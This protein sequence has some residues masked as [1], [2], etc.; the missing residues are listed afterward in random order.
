MK[1]TLFSPATLRSRRNCLHKVIIGLGFIGVLFC[2]WLIWNNYTS[3]K[4]LQEINVRIWQEQAEH[5]AQMLEAYFQARVREMRQWS[6]SNPVMVYFES[7]ALGMTMEY[8]LG[9]SL[10]FIR[11]SFLSSL[12][13]NRYDRAPLYSR[14]LLLDASG[15]RLVDT[16]QKEILSTGGGQASAGFNKLLTPDRT[17][18]SLHLMS[19]EHKSELLLS[20]PVFFKSKYVGQI[21]AWL[22][23]E[24]ISRKL[25]P[26]AEEPW[27]RRLEMAYLSF[28]DSIVLPSQ[29]VF[30]AQQ[31]PEL[32]PVQSDGGGL[33]QPQGEA[34]SVFLAS[35]STLGLKLDLEETPLSLVWIRSADVVQGSTSPNQLLVIFSLFLLLLLASSIWLIRVSRRNEELQKKLLQAQKMEAVGTLAGGIAHDFNNLLQ[36]ISG[37][38]EFMKSRRPALDKDRKHLDRVEDTVRQG[39]Q[40]VKGLLAFSRKQEPEF[41]NLDVNRLINDLLEFTERTIPRE[42]RLQADLAAD[43]PAVRGDVVQLQQILLNLINNAK[44]AIDPEQGGEISIATRLH[45]KGLQDSLPESFSGAGPLIELLVEDNGSGMDP[46]VR[47]HIFEPFFTTKDK[48]RGSGLGLAMAYGIVQEH[49][50]HIECSSKPGEGTAFRILLPAVQ[51]RAD[52]AQKDR[53]PQA[54]A[55]V[56]CARTCTILVVEDEPLLRE[57]TWE[58]LKDCGYQVEVAESGERALELYREGKRFDLLVTDVS[59]PGMTGYE[60]MSAVCE[61]EREQKIIL[62]SGDSGHMKAHAARQSG[63]VDYLQKPFSL[64][65]LQQRIRNLLG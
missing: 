13:E 59:L 45:P 21:I 18:P 37:A 49:G 36:I 63:R 15:R 16:E 27:Q 24:T 12:Q 48:K 23:L 61:L 22:D 26:R 5:R 53:D 52:E 8:G 28:K 38:V 39:E 2:G 25:I 9:A 57:M 10:S 64:E 30:E 44:D 34:D 42:V 33:S 51:G 29:A 54:E 4:K 1:L 35:G 32:S 31:L 6:R 62:V 7:K 50:G 65:S 47:E 43:L 60:L 19:N 17:S 20:G 41:K 11:N 58:F 40:L 3:Q 14:I 55:E 56:G 46:K